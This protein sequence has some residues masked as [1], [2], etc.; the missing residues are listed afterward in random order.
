MKVHPGH[1]NYSWTFVTCEHKKIFLC[2]LAHHN[3]FSFVSWIT[4]SL[5]STGSCS[6]SFLKFLFKCSWHTKLYSFQVYII[7]TW[8]FYTLQYDHLI[9]VIIC[10]SANL[11]EYYWLYFPSP[12]SLMCHPVP[13][14]SHLCGLCFSVPSVLNKFLATI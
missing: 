13:S 12:F 8:H 11:P 10:H 1:H 5:T 9:L 14:S 7:V 4:F 6:I 2:Q 3:G